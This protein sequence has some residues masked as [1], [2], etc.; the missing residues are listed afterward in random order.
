MAG[1]VI[2]PGHQTRLLQDS[3]E[4]FGCDTMAVVVFSWAHT[5]VEG[6]GFV[7]RKPQHLKGWKQG[8]EYFLHVQ[9]YHLELT[10]SILGLRTRDKDFH[11]LLNIVISDWASHYKRE[12]MTD[13]EKAQ[14]EK[15]TNS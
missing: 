6:K 12:F 14:N 5:S 4:D 9:G 3:I 1:E 11:T 8:Q 2:V 15:H 10:A 13:M 7:P